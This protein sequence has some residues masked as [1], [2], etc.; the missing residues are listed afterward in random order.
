MN[1]AFDQE[2]LKIRE[3]LVYDPTQ[4]CKLV[5]AA[6]ALSG[7]KDAV[8]IVHGR[9]GCHCGILLLRALSSNQNDI[10][11]VSSGF[12]A[13]DM[14]Y[15]AEGR[16]AGTIRL[17]YDKFKPSLIAALNCSAPVIMGDDVA[18]VVHAI[19][20][21]IPAD[22]I[23]LSTGGYEGPAWI[24]YE[25]TLTELTRYMVP[26]ET[27]SDKVN[28]IGFKQDDVK[29]YADLLEI[30][31]MLSSQGITINTVL[32]NSRF[33]ELKNAP[34]ASLNIVLGGDGIESAKIMQEKFDT[35]FVLTPYPFGLNNSIE[36]LE[37]VTKSLSKEVNEEFIA[38]EKDRIKE[39][40]ERI[41]LF[42]QGIYDMSVAVVGDAG[43]AFDLAKFLSDELCLNVKVLAIT[44]RNHI[45][46]DK[47]KTNDGYFETLL[48]EPDRFEMNEEIKTKGVEMI[49][50]SSMEKKLAWELGVPLFR[51]FYPVIDE[52][53][54]SDAPYAGF[55]G[56]THLTEKIINSV[57]NNYIEV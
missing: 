36:F 35:P 42:L 18:G 48:I 41:F 33:D 45:S 44:S 8:T 32:T 14:V 25:E 4:D 30:E 56:T 53:S 19:K 29:A 20:K 16:L 22:I 51:I 28:L 21:E 39:R 5:G 2:E 57:I 10:R 1:E 52:V 37:S 47:T 54:I 6:R 11:I 15:G 26:G 13:Q 9:P 34:K 38:I 31:R 27:E 12:R 49:F 43:R 50:G 17:C 40:I 7:V 3:G 55:T 46:L 23:T 24:G